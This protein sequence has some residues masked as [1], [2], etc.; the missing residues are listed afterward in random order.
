MSLTEKQYLILRVIHAANDDLSPVDIDQV[1]D[2]IPYETTKDS[3][4]FSLR[5]MVAGGYIE[6]GHTE[7]RRDRRRRTY[8]ATK[9]GAGIVSYSMENPLSGVCVDEDQ[10]ADEQQLSLEI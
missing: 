1:L 9:R 4:Q 10:D 2:R 6:K 3:I 8:L 7:N 5:A